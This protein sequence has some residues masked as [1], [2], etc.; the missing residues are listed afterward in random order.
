M[1]VRNSVFSLGIGLQVLCLRV[2]KN[3]SKREKYKFRFEKSNP[4]LMIQQWLP[5]PAIHVLPP[6]NLAIYLSLYMCIF[7]GLSIAIS[8]DL[9]LLGGGPGKAVLLNFWGCANFCDLNFRPRRC[10]ATKTN[11]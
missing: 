2:L 4:G 7:L 1:A 9:G 6:R 5:C 3:M 11:Q 8:V 10:L